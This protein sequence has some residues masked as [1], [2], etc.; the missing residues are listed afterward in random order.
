[1]D[2]RLIK[3]I[4][5]VNVVMG[6]VWKLGTVF[7]L[8]GVKQ[9]DIINSQLIRIVHMASYVMGFALNMGELWKQMFPTLHDEMKLRRTALLLLMFSMGVVRKKAK[10]FQSTCIVRSSIMKLQRFK[11]VRM[12]RI[13]TE[14]V[15]NRAEVLIKTCGWLRRITNVLPTVVIWTP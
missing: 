7:Q 2:F 9:L 12:G 5:M 1:M 6:V 3:G 4:Q 15:L 8:I 11:V 10:V 14:G 13:I